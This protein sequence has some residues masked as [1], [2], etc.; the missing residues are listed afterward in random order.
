M[1]WSDISKIHKALGGV[2]VKEG[3]IVSL[4][5]SMDSHYPNEVSTRRFG[6]P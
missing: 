3:R 6:M 5:P 4:L 1:R 2:Y